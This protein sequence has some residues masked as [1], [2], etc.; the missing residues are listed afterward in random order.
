MNWRI[1]LMKGYVKNMSI[2]PFY[3]MKRSVATG[4]IIPIEDIVRR[5]LEV[6]GAKDAKSFVA[7]LKKYVFEGA[8]V[9]EINIVDDDSTQDVCPEPTDTKPKDNSR[10]ATAK[11]GS[12]IPKVDP[13]QLVKVSYKKCIEL[14]AKC[15]EPRILKQAL[16]RA[17]TMARKEKTCQVLRDR[18]AE[19]G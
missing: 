8:G 15:S 13:A 19:L 5:Y 11:S 6:S 9:W 16:Q 1:G 4:D 2:S 17:S 18:L 7:W 3:V 14:A 10:A 12:V